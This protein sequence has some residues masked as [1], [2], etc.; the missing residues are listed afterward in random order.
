[1]I[2]SYKYIPS[3]KRILK[4]RGI[5]NSRVLAKYLYPLH[6]KRK[7]IETKKNMFQKSYLPITEIQSHI[8]YLLKLGM[9]PSNDLHKI[10]EESN[11][12]ENKM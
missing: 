7:I 2:N 12:R 5:L 6:I 1:M 4:L 8:K 3:K 9:K 11:Q 10:H